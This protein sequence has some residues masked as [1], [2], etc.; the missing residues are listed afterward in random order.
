[1]KLTSLIFV[2][3]LMGVNRAAASRRLTVDDVASLR[4]ITSVQL[5]P[6][7]SRLAYIVEYPSDEQHSKVP[8]TSKLWIYAVKDGTAS[9][10]EDEN[11]AWSPKWSPDSKTLAFLSSTA[12]GAQVYLMNPDTREMRRTTKHPVGINS[13]AWSRDGSKIVF[14]STPPLTEKQKRRADLGYDEIHVGPGPDQAGRGEELWTV[15]LSDGREQQV[16]TQDAH[17]L[18]YDLSPDGGTFLLATA[19][20]RWADE[21]ALRPRLVT[22]HAAGGEK[23]PYCNVQGR[24]TSATWSPDG[25]SVAYLGTS[26]GA[27]DPYPGGLYVCNA[28]GAPRNLIANSE[29]TLEQYQWIES[30]KAM[31]VVVAR[32]AHRSIARLEVADGRLTPLT[33]SPLEVAFRSPY[34]SS[35]DGSRIACV[36]ATAKTPPDIWLVEKNGEARQVSHVNP[37]VNGIQFADGE[38]FR[39]KARDGLDVTGV[40]LRPIGYRADVRYPLVVQVHGSQVGDMNEFQA[41][42][43]NWGQLLAA[44]GYAVLLPNYR[45]SLTSGAKFA[46]AD[47]GDL[48]GKDLTDILDGVDA[49]VAAG[50]ADPNRMGIGGVSYGGFLTAWAITQTTRFKA[51][52]MGL[53]ISNWIAIAGQTPAPEAMVALYWKH[54][55]DDEWQVLWNRSPSAYAKNVRTP[56]LIY[57]GEN[58]R[59]IPVSQSREFLRALQHYNVPSEFILYPRE[60]HSVIEPNHLRDNLTR[61]IEWYNRYLR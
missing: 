17:L 3:A 21:E 49:L 50:V 40:L 13:F 25:S 53:G 29:L 33:R 41:T 60:G 59:G 16:G 11:R 39:W 7:G 20:T 61:I 1:M 48:G 19:A 37:Q 26:E 56:T 9:P 58:D 44:N 24:F 22:M 2:F 28:A 10:V 34:S 5:S 38:E 18:A 23:H 45:G 52:V 43:M 47:Q 6:D 12:D 36:L 4:R 27:I 54:S 42:W 35:S 57:A 31:I 32:G 46:R 14:V 55:P 8:P 15:S 30:G 51:A